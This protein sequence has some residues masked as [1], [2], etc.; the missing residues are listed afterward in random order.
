M[1]ANF[2]AG[3]F[4]AMELKYLFLMK[5]GQ[6]SLEKTDSH[7]IVYYVLFIVI[8]MYSTLQTPFASYRMS[9]DPNLSDSCPT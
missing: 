9:Q 1:M 3:T 4:G 7:V 6:I 2:T 5:Q 8:K